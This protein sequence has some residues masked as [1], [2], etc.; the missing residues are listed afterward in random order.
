MWKRFR[1]QTTKKND[2]HNFIKVSIATPSFPTCTRFDSC[3][4]RFPIYPLFLPEVFWALVLMT[5]LLLS[6]RSQFF[7]SWPG[8]FFFSALSFSPFS[9]LECCPTCNCKDSGLSCLQQCSTETDYFLSGWT[10]PQR[11]DEPVCLVLIKELEIC[12]IFISNGSWNQ[13]CKSNA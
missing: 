8:W 13:K 4:Q 11:I 12:P 7:N 1:K 5:G 2:K 3:A 6:P 9:K 10:K